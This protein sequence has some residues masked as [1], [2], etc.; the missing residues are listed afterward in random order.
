M[1]DI[2]GAEIFW[3]FF[4]CYARP[5]LK[6][7]NNASLVLSITNPALHHFHTPSVI[8]FATPVTRE[9]RALKKLKQKSHDI[10]TGTAAR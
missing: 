2:G 3:F 1:P 9:A 10:R 5:V 7:H 6:G 4:K 8:I